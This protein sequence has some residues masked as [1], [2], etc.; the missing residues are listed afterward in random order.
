MPAD[1]GALIDELAGE[2]AALRKILD[3]LSDADWR[4]P[5]PAPGWT[6]ADQVSHLAHFD[7]V[8][9]T[10]ATDPGAFAA[11]AERLAAT[12]GIHP[13]AIAAPYREPRPAGLIDWFAP[14]S[15][16]LPL[17]FAGLDPAI[18]AAWFR[19]STDPAS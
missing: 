8:A 14:A 15:S 6:I 4:L 5:T 2:T 13:D 17:V 10:S 12:S 1:L 3:P 11:E 18:P 7:D 16:Q 9:V 19:P